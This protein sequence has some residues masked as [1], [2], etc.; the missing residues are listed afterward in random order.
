MGSREAPAPRPHFSSSIRPAGRM[1]PDLAHILSG[2][3]RA[4]GPAAS[5]WRPS[6]AALRAVAELTHGGHSVRIR[7]EQDAAAGRYSIG[8]CPRKPRGIRKGRKSRPSAPRPPTPP[9][10]HSHAGL[11][12]FSTPPVPRPAAGLAPGVLSSASSVPS[13]LPAGR[14]IPRPDPPSSSPEPSPVAQPR[15]VSRAL[16]GVPSPE[17]PSS[18][19]SVAARPPQPSLRRS[20]ASAVSADVCASLAAPHISQVAAPTLAPPSSPAV[21]SS[22]LVCLSGTPAPP[23]PSAVATPGSAAQHAAAVSAGMVAAAVPIY[24]DG[25]SSPFPAPPDVAV[26]P[27]G[28]PLRPRVP[29]R[30]GIPQGQRVPCPVPRA[31]APLRAR[32][33]GKGA[34]YAN[35]VGSA[36]A[37]VL[38]SMPPLPPVGAKRAAAGLAAQPL[39]HGSATAVRQERAARALVAILPPSCATYILWDDSA[40]VSAMSVA[41]RAEEVVSVLAKYG[42]HSLNGAATALGSLLAWIRRHRPSDACVGG[43]AF[44]KYLEANP[45]SQTT[46][47]QLGWLCTWTGLDLPVGGAVSH[48][49]RGGSSGSSRPNEAFSL[50]VLLGLEWL[51]RITPAPSSAARPRDGG[52]SPNCP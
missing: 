41:E 16:V 39:V 48:G 49:F 24:Q 6:A 8:L 1:D 2:Q 3:P 23:L 27:M 4:S 12:A 15:A 35:L 20:A 7:A 45:P 43:I 18:S 32:F 52:F 34:K 50:F 19:D 36:F 38:H 28:Q 37:C 13:S 17:A 5:V 44:R 40:V 26:R 10:A 14:A 22:A 30:K 33:K 25:P 31:G 9:A 29:R 11:G 21:A 46:L 51:R 42:E 47:A